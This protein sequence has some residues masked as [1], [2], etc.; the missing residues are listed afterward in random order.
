M[1]R[2]APQETHPPPA[3]EKVRAGGRSRVSLNALLAG[4]VLLVITC[5]MLL[6][7]HLAM[8]R[9]ADQTMRNSLRRAALACALTVDPVVHS[10]L[11]DASQE[12]SPPYLEACKLLENAKTAMEGPE[13]FRFVY[14]CVLRDRE[15]RFILDPTPAGDA[16]GDGVEDKSHLMESYPEAS[17]ELITT[18]KTGEVTVM[19]EPQG[20]RWG[21]F[22]SGHAPVTDDSGKVIAAVGVDMDL[23]FYLNEIRSIRRTTMLAALGALVVSIIAGY[24]VWLHER[25][26]HSA[27]KNLEIANKAANSANDAKSRFL[28]TMSHEI[29]T[30]MN[31]VIGMTELLLTTPLSAGQLDRVRT[32]QTSG[33]SLLALL[34]DILDFTKIETGSLA[35]VKKPVRVDEVATGVLEHF[36]EEAAAKGLHLRLDIARDASTMIHTDPERLR[37]I[38]MNLVSN[39]VKFTNS[40]SVVLSVTPD[41]M[42]AGGGGIRFCVTDTGIGLAQDARLQ[43]FQPFSQVDSSSNRQYGGTGLGLAICDRLCRA[44][45]GNIGLESEPGK[46]SSFHFTLPAP[47]TCADEEKSPE[48]SA[49]SVSAR[50][51]STD[52]QHGTALLICSDSLARTLLLRLLEK[53]GWRTIVVKTLENAGASEASPDLVVFDLALARGTPAAYAKEVSTMFPSARLAAMDPGL[54]ACQR[55]AVIDCGVS[56]VLPLNPSLENLA[57]LASGR[58]SG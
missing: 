21:T 44:M 42:E 27:I 26:M 53:H 23:A 16:D 18:L 8:T 28:A 25:R 49:K 12:G 24:G 36:A 48:L 33:E 31:G 10:S 37:Q 43:L 52:S 17:H 3:T 1:N 54:S 11:T 32:I 13:K 45:G 19:K 20:D 40:G 5:A 55:A 15:V 6:H 35:L 56:V 38:L 30:P 7:F 34:D 47:T 39:A 9:N 29:R 50:T 58:G 41:V 51:S 22:L 46:G 4:L 14:T 57:S 2:P